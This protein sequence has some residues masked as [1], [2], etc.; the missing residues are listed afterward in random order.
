MGAPPRLPHL[1]QT[2]ARRCGLGVTADRQAFLRSA[3][4][5]GLGAATGA[6]C[7]TL[8]TCGLRCIDFR[9]CISA[10]PACGTLRS[11]CAPAVHRRTRAC[12]SPGAGAG[13]TGMSLLVTPFLM[14]ACRHFLP[15]TEGS[16]VQACR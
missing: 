7:A 12:P 2:Q 14:Q 15:D 16:P 1:G 11:S 9:E 8:A 4:F 6:I 3:C 10:V 5:S 13:I